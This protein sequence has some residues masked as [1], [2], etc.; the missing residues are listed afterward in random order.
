MDLIERYRRWK[1]SGGGQDDSS[2]SDDDKYVQKN[3]HFYL[4]VARV[5]RR[6]TRTTQRDWTFSAPLQLRCSGH[7]FPGHEETFFHPLI[8]AC[9]VSMIVI[10]ET[11]IFNFSSNFYGYFFSNFKF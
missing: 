11:L 4:S 6:I 1:A 2:S 10:F 8:L 3:V 9:N 5:G 7:L